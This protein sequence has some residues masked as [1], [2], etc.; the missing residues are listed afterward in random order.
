M[1]CG[2]HKINED[3]IPGSYEEGVMKYKVLDTILYTKDDM[4]GDGIE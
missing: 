2:P 1:S 4:G 3:D